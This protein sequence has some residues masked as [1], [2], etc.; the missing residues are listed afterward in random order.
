[1]IP[2]YLVWMFLK[3]VRVKGVI[4]HSSYLDV[5][6]IM[7][8]KRGNDL[9]G[10]IYPYLNFFFYL[11]NKA[12]S[13]FFFY[14]FKFVLSLFGSQEKSKKKI[15]YAMAAATNNDSSMTTW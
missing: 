9:N 1:M 13:F 14:F 5:L 10:Q 4:S 11:I 2:L 8:E 3:L 15:L 7:M 12:K 6:K